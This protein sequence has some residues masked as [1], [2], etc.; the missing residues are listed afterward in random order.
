MARALCMLLLA[1]LFTL[2]SPADGVVYAEEPAVS[3]ADV[4]DPA[5]GI[6]SLDYTE[7]T[8]SR[9]KHGRFQP[10]FPVCRKG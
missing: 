8:L 9:G 1:A 2:I 10:M 3:P 7:L 6:L 4:S 5:S